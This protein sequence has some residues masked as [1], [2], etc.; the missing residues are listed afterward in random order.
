VSPHLQAA[1]SIQ[2]EQLAAEI[3]DTIAL[4]M[5]F[6]LHDREF[7]ELE[8]TWRAVDFLLRRLDPDSDV[9]LYLIDLSKAELF[10]DV[11]GSQDPE[12][13][14]L[15]RLLVE[16][17]GD[18]HGEAPFA[19]IAGLYT[20]EPDEIRALGAMG[21]LAR[22]A[23]APLLCSLSPRFMGTESFA[24]DPDDWQV[25]LDAEAGREWNALRAAPE[26]SWI[27]ACLPRFIL[28]DPYTKDSV[29]TFVFEEM[30]TPPQHSDYLWG[31]PAVAVACLIGESF[32]RDGWDIQLRDT[33]ID[34]LPV[35]TW[36]HDGDLYTTPCAE[37]WMTERMVDRF[38]SRGIMPLAS[39]KHSDAIRLVRLQ[40][41]ADPPA[42]LRAR[43]S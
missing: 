4:A 31:N 17:A 20:F 8:G 41:I 18:L 29:D 13:T 40:S 12:G 22:E 28:R 25:P 10:E 24:T 27:G 32:A 3:E 36:K 38:L 34:R 33:E 7:Q 35:H 16:E 14:G 11:L 2:Q 42:P 23:G 15:Y 21:R 26:A 1:P 19:V 39:V 43:W 30:T 5:R 6:V 9:Q 37:C